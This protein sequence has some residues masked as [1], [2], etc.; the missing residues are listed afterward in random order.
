MR[1]LQRFRPVTCPNAVSFLVIAAPSPVSF[2]VNFLF[3]FPLDP[4]SFP[5]TDVPSVVFAAWAS[6]RPYFKSLELPHLV[7]TSQIAQVVKSLGESDSRMARQH[8]CWQNGRMA[9]SARTQHR[10]MMTCASIGR[11]I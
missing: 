10:P 4:V 6:L 3:R 1:I 2:P 11:C 9:V 5:G 8:D 7:I